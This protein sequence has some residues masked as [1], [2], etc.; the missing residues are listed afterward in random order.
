M[1]TILAALINGFVVSVPLAAVVWLALRVS[2][3]WVNAAT[4]YAIWWIVLAMVI[5]LPFRYL[6]SRPS[7]RYAPIA[8]TPVAL[9]AAV[10][11]QPPSVLA[12]SSRPMRADA[13]RFPVR[14]RAGFVVRMGY[15][16]YG[17]S[18]LS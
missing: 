15:G 9:P 16:L 6:P 13:P 5:C 2:R 7:A 14:S 10:V 1:S 3:R 12:R 8:A 17:R 11:A 4:R 18:P